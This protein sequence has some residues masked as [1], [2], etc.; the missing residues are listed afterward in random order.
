MNWITIYITGKEGFKNEV[1][2][3]VRNSNLK[4]MKGNNEGGFNLVD[5][6]LYWLDNKNSLRSFKEE[7]SAKIIWKYRIRFYTSLEEFLG[8]KQEE[9]TTE[10]SPHEK[11]MITKMQYLIK[12]KNKKPP[13]SKLTYTTF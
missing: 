12:P 6:D 5:H 1:S 11:S 7:I 13:K 10:F 4:Y 9:P 8:S 3:K 2:K